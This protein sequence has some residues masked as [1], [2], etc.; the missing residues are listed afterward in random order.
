AGKKIGD[1][2]LQA[3]TDTKADCA[4]EDREDGQIY[5]G[6]A[7]TDQ[8]RQYDQ[9]DADDFGDQNLRGALDFLDLHDPPLG[10]G[11][12]KYRQIKQQEQRDDSLDHDQRRKAE[13]ADV[14]AYR[15]ESSGCFIQNTK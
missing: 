15:I 14:K 7:D 5:S 10:E 4:G 1:D 6:A 13:G 2:F 8:K 9:R 11:G 12:D 3:E